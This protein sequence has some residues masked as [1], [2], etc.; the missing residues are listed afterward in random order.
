MQSWQIQQVWENRGGGSETTSVPM[1]RDDG[2]RQ[3]AGEQ[4]EHGCYYMH[5]TAHAQDGLQAPEAVLP[6]RGR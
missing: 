5:C 6:E 2:A 3:A 1:L 4:E